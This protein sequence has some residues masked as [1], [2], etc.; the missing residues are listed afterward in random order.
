M[1]PSSWYTQHF[2]DTHY[3]TPPTHSTHWCSSPTEQ[4][5]SDPLH[6]YPYDLVT[7]ARN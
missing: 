1:G 7:S 6:H 3:P 2:T 4:P 5:Y